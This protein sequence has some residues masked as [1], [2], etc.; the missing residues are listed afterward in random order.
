MIRDVLREMGKEEEGILRLKKD[1]KLTVH[2]LT[3]R[4]SIHDCF[5]SVRPV[6]A[7]SL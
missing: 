6:I 7:S 3:R 4:G 5:T 2:H 1:E